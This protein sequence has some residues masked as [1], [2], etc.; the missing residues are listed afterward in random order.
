MWDLMTAKYPKQTTANT[1]LFRVK[2]Y[3][4]EAGPRKHMRVESNVNAKYR[5]FVY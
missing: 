5:S 1:R 3:V 4:S 2:L